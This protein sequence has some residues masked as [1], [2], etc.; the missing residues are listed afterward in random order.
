MTTTNKPSIGFWIISA[1]ALLWNLMGVNAY[2]QQAYMTDSYKEMYTPEKLALM[3]STPSWAIGAFAIAVFAAALG[4]I[5]LLLRK[6]IANT[7]FIISFMAIVVQN[8]DGFM[9][10]NY[11]EF[12]NMELSMTFMIPIIGIFLIW[13]SKKAIDNGWI[14]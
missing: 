13:Y 2:I 14:K 9:R 1:I 3:E 8:I 7:L 5:A 12:N 4:C 6:K 10:F 11:S